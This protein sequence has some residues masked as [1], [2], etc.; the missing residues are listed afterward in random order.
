MRTYFFVPPLPSLSGGLAVIYQIAGHLYAAGHDVKLVHRDKDTPGLTDSKVPCLDWDELKLDSK[1]LWVVPEGWPNALAPGLEA[2]CRNLVYVQNWAYL[3]SAL[4][5][6]VKW[7]QLPVDFLSVSVPVAQFIKQ[8]LHRDS[9]IL[10]PGIDRDIFCPAS[11]KG[12][13]VAF[14]TN[15]T[16]RIHSL[17]IGW[18]PRK[19]KAMATQARQIIEGRDKV[20]ARINWIEIQGKSPSQVAEILQD[21][22]IFMGTGFPEGLGLPPLEAM[23]CGALPIT[24]T[25][26]GGWDYLRQ[27]LPILTVL[28]EFQGLPMLAPPTFTVMQN[29]HILPSAPN[30]FLVPD[31]DSISLAVAVEHAANLIVDKDPFVSMMLKNGQQT[32]DAF[33]LKE[34]AKHVSKIW[35]KLENTF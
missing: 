33:S 12:N 26:Y 31:G 1:D 27:G 35:A 18:M 15:N 19:N 7:Q 29:D 16:G 22:H 30:S 24:F 34:Q 11:D 28:T 8:I 23:A 2:K 4:P 14:R 20:Q 9:E 13:S 25:G 32:A 21:C 10:R 3:F 6:G 17:N 5:Q